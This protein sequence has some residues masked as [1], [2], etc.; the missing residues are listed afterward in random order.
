VSCRAARCGTCFSLSMSS[1]AEFVLAREGHERYLTVVAHCRHTAF[2][3]R[4]GGRLVRERPTSF[5]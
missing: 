4:A 5:L 3:D 2:P 1:R